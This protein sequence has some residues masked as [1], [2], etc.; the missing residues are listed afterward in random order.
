MSACEVVADLAHHSD[1]LWVDDAGRTGPGAEYLYS[2]FA[3]DSGENARRLAH[4]D[5]R[6]MEPA[7]F[8]HVRPHRSHGE[9]ITRCAGGVT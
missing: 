5:P 3:V 7:E 8:N 2:V 4:S 1:C 9:G 6:Q